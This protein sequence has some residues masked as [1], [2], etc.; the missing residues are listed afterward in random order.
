ML[1]FDLDGCCWD[2]EMYE[3]WGGGSPFTQAK[4][5]PSPCPSPV[6]HLVLNIVLHLVLHLVLHCVL[7]PVLVIYLVFIFAFNVKDSTRF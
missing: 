4:V 5:R 7:L 3:L 6:L 2:P 1:V